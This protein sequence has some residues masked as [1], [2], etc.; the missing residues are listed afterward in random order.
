MPS[1]QGSQRRDVRRR[2]ATAGLSAT[3][4]EPVGEASDPRPAGRK[5]NLYAQKALPEHHPSA[6]V[7]IPV[8]VLPFLGAVVGLLLIP[9]LLAGL[10]FA[11][12][13]MDQLEASLGDRWRH[14]AA[15]V[16][17]LLNLASDRSLQA[18]VAVGCFLLAAALA[19]TTKT[20]RKHRLDDH[21]G[22]YRAWGWL[23]TLSVAAAVSVVIPIDRLVA[24]L[25]VDATT[26]N[27]GASGRGW[28]MLTVLIAWLPIGLWAAFPL[29]QRAFPSLWMFAALASWFS[30]EGIEQALLAGWQPMMWHLGEQAAWDRASLILQAFPPSLAAVGMLVACRGVV[31]EARGLVAPKAPRA[32]PPKG[33]RKAAVRTAPPEPAPASLQHDLEDAASLESPDDASEADS[34]AEANTWPLADDDDTETSNVGGVPHVLENGGNLDAKIDE[35]ADEGDDEAD[36]VGDQRLSKAERRRLRK[37]AR[38]NRAA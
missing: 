36:S 11:Q 35:P 22:R 14:A 29:T 31:R 20:I 26:R 6:A 38:R 37:L 8:R 33:A 12:P 19:T 27:L 4:P 23:S 32:K 18:A 10:T 3:T 5:P 13:E 30:A 34:N 16:R 15:A 9:S 17:D 2:L 24:A 1:F 25:L 21:Q 28:W 7:R